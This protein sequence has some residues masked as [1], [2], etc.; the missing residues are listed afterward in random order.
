MV[1]E[2]AGLRVFLKNEYEFTTRLC[3]AYL[4]KDQCSPVDISVSASE[5]DIAEEKALTPNNSDG[6]I[7]N[8]CLYRNLCREMPVFNRFL[9]HSSVIEYKGNGY[10]FLGRSG[11]GKST[12]TNL[13]CKYVDNVKIINGDKPIL[14]IRDGNVIAYGTPWMGKEGLGCN[15]SVPL[16]GL[17]FLQQA[18][19]NEILPLS[20]K[21]TVHCVF[22]QILNPIKQDSAEKTLELVDVLVRK[23]PSYL[24]KCTI[25]QEAVAC[26]FEAMTG[27]KYTF[28]EV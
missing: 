9:L 8:V 25:S 4:S 2:I 16:K 22:P 17:C 19:Y 6:Y 15:Q 20:I 23:T 3:R 11:T 14:E 5:E 13:W 24:L 28:K 1:Y 27:E 12:H 7:E 26:S 21:E 10:A 18:K